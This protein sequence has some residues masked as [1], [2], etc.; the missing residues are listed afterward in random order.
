MSLEE[1]SEHA[2]LEL[3]RL[4]E[5]R[6][7]GDMSQYRKIVDMLLGGTRQQDGKEVGKAST[8]LTKREIR[9]ALEMMGVK[10]NRRTVNGENK[11]GSKLA[12]G[13]LIPQEDGNAGVNRLEQERR[14]RW[15][16]RTRPPKPRPEGGPSSMA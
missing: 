14:A 15:L 2:R 9:D 3:A 8:P 1:R 11:T 10:L 16:G 4:A 13:S 12:G 5:S 7:S 6:L